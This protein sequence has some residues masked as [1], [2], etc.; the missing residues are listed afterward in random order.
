M[1]WRWQACAP[2]RSGASRSACA[3]RSPRTTPINCRSCSTLAE[4][5]GVDKFYLSHLVYA[6]RGNKHRGDDAELEP[7]AQRRWTC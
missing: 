6:G 5:E 1:P 2:A 7:L 4:E 3:S